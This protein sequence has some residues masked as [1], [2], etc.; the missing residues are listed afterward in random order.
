MGYF[1]GVDVGGVGT[2]VGADVGA[3]VGAGVGAEEGLDVGEPV[4]ADVGTTVGAGVGAGEG[5]DVGEGVGAP[6]NIAPEVRELEPRETVYLVPIST[7]MQSMSLSGC[8]YTI[9]TQASCIVI[10]IH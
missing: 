2:P 10:T 1:V 8:M 5:L 7:T 9:Y 3:A 4:G 6:I